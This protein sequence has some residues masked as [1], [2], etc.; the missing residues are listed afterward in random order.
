MRKHFLILLSVSVFASIIN[1][2]APLKQSTQRYT[3]GRISGRVDTIF[4]DMALNAQKKKELLTVEL[5]NAETLGMT[6]LAKTIRSYLGL[7][8][9][10]VQSRTE[11][12]KAVAAVGTSAATLI[13]IR[14][15]GVS[16]IQKSLI[17]SKRFAIPGVTS[18]GQQRDATLAL[19]L[20]KIAGDDV[21][22]KKVTTAIAAHKK[23]VAALTTE[24]SVAQL[25][26]K[27]IEHISTRYGSV[28]TGVKEEVAMYLFDLL[29]YGI[30]KEG[31]IGT[32]VGS[33]INDYV[34]YVDDA[35]AFDAEELAVPYADWADTI[36]SSENSLKYMILAV[37]FAAE[38]FKKQLRNEPLLQQLHDGISS[39]THRALEILDEQ[40]VVLTPTEKAQPLVVVA[41]CA[42]HV[43]KH[44]DLD[45]AVVQECTRIGQNISQLLSDYEI[46][47]SASADDEAVLRLR[48]DIAQLSSDDIDTLKRSSSLSA[49]QFST[50]I[51]DAGE[52]SM[53]DADPSVESLYGPQSEEYEDDYD[54]SSV[55]KKSSMSPKA[56]TIAVAIGVLIVGGLLEGI[57]RYAATKKQ[58]SGI[59]EFFSS[60]RPSRLVMKD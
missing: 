58:S 44:T 35:S 3:E 45:P 12:K 59:W 49:D 2:R 37:S 52:Q 41:R 57:G 17:Y 4:N 56:V 9:V 31:T 21:V 22:Q 25:F 20:E 33:F 16:V 15:Y 23:I 19:F 1:A 55:D 28:T 14:S 13:Q 40:G 11:Q 30:T 60:I 26:K 8:T 38:L 36:I 50:A 7:A 43:K 24:Q 34:T 5:E 46:V 32:V 51:G 48:D 18:I 29:V 27:L 6:D 10:Q 47:S 39:Q 54:V 53:V 42:Q